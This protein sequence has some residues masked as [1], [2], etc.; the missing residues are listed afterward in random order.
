MIADPIK[1]QAIISKYKDSEFEFVDGKGW[2]LKNPSEF[3]LHVIP[4][5]ERV[6]KSVVQIL[7]RKGRIDFDD[8]LQDYS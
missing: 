5:N 1:I 4:L 6:E 8:V 2:W 3:Y 7:R